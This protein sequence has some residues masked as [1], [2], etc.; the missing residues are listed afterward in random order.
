MR[1]KFIVFEGGEGSGKTTIVERLKKAYPDFV[2]TKDPGGTRLGEE[3]RELLMSDKT[4]GIDVRSELLLF[5]AGRAQMIAEII[6]PALDSGKIVV[7]NRFAL[8]SIAYQ[9]YGRQRPELLPLYRAVSDS[10]LKGY[11][12]DACIL[13]DVTPEIGIARAR[14]RPDEPTRF[15]N[16]ELD[17]HI[18]VREGYKK[19]IA[20]FGTPMIIDADK[21]LVEVWTQVENAVQSV[22]SN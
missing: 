18:R 4:K 2:Y 8:S 7:S 1:G 5:L 17:F 15:D 6:K 3:I 19:H 11:I 13:L 14:S 22:L 10:M 20:E 16:E 21:P 9:I 12:P